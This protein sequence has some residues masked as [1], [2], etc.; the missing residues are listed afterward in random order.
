MSHFIEATPATAHSDF[1][2][3]LEVLSPQQFT[4]A[5]RRH[6]S[7]QCPS[8]GN[9]YIHKHNLNRH[10]RQE[11]GKEPRFLC[12][13]CPYKTKHKSS[14]GRHIRCRHLFPLVSDGNFKL[15]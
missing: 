13:H 1:G 15:F 8:C 9:F 5:P 7:F 2:N 11:C 10:I 4:A 14:L 6:T 3:Q 12:P